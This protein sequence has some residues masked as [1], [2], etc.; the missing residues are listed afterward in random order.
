MAHCT[1]CIGYVHVCLFFFVCVFLYLRNG[2]ALSPPILQ[3]IRNVKSLTRSIVFLNHALGDDELR[4]DEMPSPPL[5][6]I[7]FG[8][9]ATCIFIIYRNNTPNCCKQVIFLFFS[10]STLCL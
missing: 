8:S 4:E 7:P 1:L 5:I 9:S 10:H 3:N 6:A 2:N